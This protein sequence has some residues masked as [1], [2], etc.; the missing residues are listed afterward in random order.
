MALSIQNASGRATDAQWPYVPWYTAPPPA[1]DPSAQ[2]GVLVIVGA[3]VPTA[4]PFRWDG[5]TQDPPVLRPLNTSGGG[6]GGSASAVTNV[7]AAPVFASV[8]TPQPMQSVTIPAGALNAAGTVATVTA[9]GN[10]NVNTVCTVT[11]SMQLGGGTALQWSFPAVSADLGANGQ[12][13]A[14]VTLATAATGAGGSVIAS[15][16]LSY[17][18]VGVSSAIVVLG[19]TTFSANLTAALPLQTSIQFSAQT[20]LSVATQV[21]TTVVIV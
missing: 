14:A 7:V 4:L 3:T 8:T 15:G 1:S 5:S 11:V 21:Y 13:V 9:G 12:F 19:G 6:G 17:T 18:Y 2:D 20:S 16:V 10:F